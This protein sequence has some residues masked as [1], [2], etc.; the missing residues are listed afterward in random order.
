MLPFDDRD[1][2]I[3]LDG[4]IVL[5][6]EAKSHVLSHALHYGS[7]VFEGERSYNGKIFNNSFPKFQ[8]KTI[9]LCTCSAFIFLN[10]SALIVILP[11]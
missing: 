3:W 2:Y 6:R 8:K 5:W 1:G 7:Q 10:C 11:S 9:A 4:D